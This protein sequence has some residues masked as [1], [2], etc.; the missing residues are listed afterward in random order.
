MAFSWWDPLRDLLALQ[1]RLD[2]FNPDQT[3]GWLPPVDVYETAD[4]YV[5]TVE[6]PGLS[7]EHID[8]RMHDDRLV[9]RGIRPTQTVSCEQ[10]H[11]IERG[12]GPFSRTFH[13]P[14]AAATDRIAADLND[15]VLTVTVPKLPDESPRRIPVE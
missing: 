13:L 12:Y 3:P 5:I 1:D 14:H 11:R 15:G 4:Q 6:V 10:Y 2:R 7:R 8:I 9:L